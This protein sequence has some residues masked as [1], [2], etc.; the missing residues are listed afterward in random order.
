MTS[1]EQAERDSERA[2]RW[3]TYKTGEK[4]VLS[5]I[6]ENLKLLRKGE[7]QNVDRDVWVIEVRDRHDG[8]LYSKFISETALASQVF[9]IDAKQPY[10]AGTLD[11]ATFPVQIGGGVVIRYLGEK[12]ND[13]GGTTTSW[14]VVVVDEPETE[15]GGADDDIAF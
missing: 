7:F 10:D 5:G 12:E 8:Q 1:F 4:T 3:N 9:G 2:V 11:P 14:K 13:F 15:P 6:V